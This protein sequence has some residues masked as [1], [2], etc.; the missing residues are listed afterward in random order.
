MPLKV[1]LSI[2]TFGYMGLEN[3]NYV[4]SRYKE[5]VFKVCLKSPDAMRTV[6]QTIE[7]HDKFEGFTK[8]DDAA[9]A[10]TTIIV[11]IKT[12]TSRDQ[13]KVARNI[14]SQILENIEHR[15]RGLTSIT[16][17]TPIATTS[18]RHRTRR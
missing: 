1:S 10:S 16:A 8:I 18:T 12:G 15:A 9:F 17:A 2:T 6:K 14:A 4:N 11:R 7:G 13:D 5:L 3:C